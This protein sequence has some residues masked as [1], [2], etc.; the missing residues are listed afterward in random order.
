MAKLIWSKINFQSV[1]S[2]NIHWQGAYNVVL[3]AFKFMVSLIN[4]MYEKDRERERQRAIEWERKGNREKNEK[5]RER[6]TQSDEQNENN[7]NKY[8]Q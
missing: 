8:Q 4:C 7:S 1:T 2:S 3:I 5:Y 6:D